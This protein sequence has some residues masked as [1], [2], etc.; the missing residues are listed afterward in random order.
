MM[1]TQP[2]EKPSERW[3]EQLAL[4][5]ELCILDPKD[6]PHTNTQGKIPV[7][8]MGCHRNDILVDMIRKLAGNLP[9]QDLK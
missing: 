3:F 7:A 5:E 2:T 8:G 1:S 6:T 9:P 4:A